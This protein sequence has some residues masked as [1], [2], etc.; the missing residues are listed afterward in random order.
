MEKVLIKEL[1]LHN[2]YHCYISHEKRE[3]SG[4][5][6]IEICD[7]GD[8]L[9]NYALSDKTPLDMIELF[10]VHISNAYDKGHKDGAHW[11]KTQ[12]RFEIKKLL[13]I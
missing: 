8:L 4:T 13:T 5:Y 11:G 9:F 1:Q 7:G 10:A 3:V 2:S 12:L 6:Y